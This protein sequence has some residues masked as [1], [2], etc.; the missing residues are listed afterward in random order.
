ML[1]NLNSRDGLFRY[2]KNT[3]WVLGQRVMT[4]FIALIVSIWTARHLGPELFGELNFAYNFALLFVALAPLGLNRILDRELVNWPKAHTELMSTTFFLTLSGSVAAYCIMLGV[5]IER[6]YNNQSIALIAVIGLIAFFQINLLYVSLLLSQVKGKQLAIATVIALTLSN[7]LKVVFILIKAPIVYFA[8]GFVLDWLLL[9]P[10][11]LLAAK[12][13]IPLPS[14]KYFSLDRALSLLRHSWPYILTG[15]MIS[16]YMK[17]DAVMIKE[18]MGDYAV[19]QYSAASRLSEGV[20]F[21]PIAIVASLYPAIVNAKNTSSELYNHRISNLYSLMFFL[22]IAVALPVS[23]ISPFLIKFLYGTEYSEAA[24]VLIIHI[25]AS[26]FVFLGVTSSRWLLT[27]NLQII[28]IGNTFLGAVSNILLN[29]WLIP[30][31][32]I[33]GAAWASIISYAFSGYISFIIWRS[34]RQ[35]FYLMTRSFFRLPTLKN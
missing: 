8:I 26:V 29:L 17:I 27:E 28:S 23:A 32:G 21:L 12:A 6:N 18:M 15:I 1:T 33:E 20:Y 3:S 10:L 9:L 11:L 13:H 2:L 24:G 4:T 35:N 19:G 16:L 14:I 25:W 5:A 7:V 22:A 30:R 34:T 31:F